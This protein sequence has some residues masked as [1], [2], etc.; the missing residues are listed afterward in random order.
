MS[1]NSTIRK[2]GPFVGA[3]TV[4]TFPF[5]FK[6]FA[7][8]DLKVVTADSA[9]VETSLILN[10]D[11]TAALNGNQDS[12]PGGTITLSAALPVGKTMIIT[13]AIAETQTVALT[14]IGGFFPEVINAALDR[15]TIMLQQLQE[16]ADRSL[17]FQTTDSTG[18]QLPSAESRANGVLGFGSDG[19]PTIL[20]N[21][22]PAGTVLFA[23]VLT[24]TKNDTNKTFTI[25][26]LGSPIGKT[27]AWVIIWRNY[28]L[29]NGVGY[30]LGPSPGQ[31]TL[32]TAPSDSDDLYAQGVY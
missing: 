13:T 15:I 4:S 16:Q 27:P 8:T 9:G 30:T 20:G 32:A 29:I 24:G 5:S 12:N 17:R 14:N 11:F 7:S 6:V 21:F 26:N 31:V 19:S 2:V 22:I 18:T 3:G 1:V 23:G 28:P 10:S 25:T